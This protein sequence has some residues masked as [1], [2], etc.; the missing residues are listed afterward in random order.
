MATNPYI[1]Y[2]VASEQE[3]YEDLIIESLQIYNKS[4]SSSWFIG[5]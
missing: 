2:N 1:Q 3:L 4:Y 5:L